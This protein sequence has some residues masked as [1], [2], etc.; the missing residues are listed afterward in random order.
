MSSIRALTVRPPWSDCILTGAKEVENRTWTRSW[1]GTILL[2]ASATV[3]RAALA[4]PLVT[5]ALPPE[6]QLVRGAVVAVADLVEIHTCDGACS[7]WA[8]PGRFHWQLANV[9][10]LSEP[11]NC[12]GQLGLWRPEPELL[13]QVADLAPQLRVRLEAG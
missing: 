12:R 7:R 11:V 5:H 6:Y 1:R 10:V 9:D 4:H 8:E 13:R 2:T 3:D